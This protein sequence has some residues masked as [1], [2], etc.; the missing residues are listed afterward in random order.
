MAVGQTG[1]GSWNVSAFDATNTVSREWADPGFRRRP[2]PWGT[3]K[4]A[5]PNRVPASPCLRT[6]WIGQSEFRRGGPMFVSGREAVF[7]H[8][9]RLDQVVI[10][11]VPEI[12]PQQHSHPPDSRAA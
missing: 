10:D 12:D 5:P 6:G 4:S 3:R 8:G 7:Q 9:L 2:A 1:W 11:Q